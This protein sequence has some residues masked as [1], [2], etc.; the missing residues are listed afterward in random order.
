MGEQLAFLV[1]TALSG[2][3]AALALGWLIPLPAAAHV[4]LALAA[5]V[6]PLILGAMLHFAPVLTRSVAPRPA[7]RLLPWLAQ[8]GGIL[9]T[10]AF[11]FPEFLVAGR[12]LAAIAALAAAAIL[13]AWMWRRGRQAL[14]SPH[15]GLNWYLAALACLAL[16]LLAVLAMHP[17]PEHSLALKRFHLH[18]NLLGLIGLTA[19]GTVQVLLPTAAGR[20][21]AQVAGRLRQDL[22]FALAAT[23]LTAA[24]AAGIPGLAW[25]G[26]ALWLIPLYRLLAAWAKLYPAE[27]FAWHGAVPSLAAAMLGLALALLAGAL[28]GAGHIQAGGAGHMFILAF[29]LPLVTGA[30]SQLLPLWLRPG[31]QTPWHGETRQRLGRWSGIRALLFMSGGIAAVAGWRAGVLAAALGLAWFI[32]QLL[33]ALTYS[34][35][36]QVE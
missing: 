33:A 10:L 21:D 25:A 13:A 35:R 4:H 16:A 15:P 32:A 28:H 27:I 3:A 24:G 6:M 5:G 19:V 17:W 29:L 22:R 14:G 23:L 11:L 1:A 18:L 7:I 34:A 9:A 2:I 30:V 31:A 20:G 36:I 8:G 12:N 26:L